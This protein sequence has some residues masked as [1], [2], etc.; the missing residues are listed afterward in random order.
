MLRLTLSANGVTITTTPMNLALTRAVCNENLQHVEQSA[1]ADVAYEPDLF[2]LLVLQDNITAS[3]T[4]NDTALFTGRLGSGINWE[5]RG[6]PFPADHIRVTITDNTYLLDRKTNAEI[7]LIDTTVAAAAQKICQDCGV[8]IAA[9]AALPQTALGVFVV[10]RDVSYLT[11]LD[12]L[13]FQYGYSFYFDAAGH[14]NLFHYADVPSVLPAA[15]ASL[16]LAGVSVSHRSKTHG[17][18]TVRYNPVVKKQNELVYF[19]GGGYNADGSPAPVV[20]QPGVYYPFDAAP[21]VETAEGRVYQDFTSGYAETVR[22]YNGEAEFRRSQKTTLLYTQNHSLVEDWETGIVVDRAEFESKRAS[23]RVRNTGAADANLYQLSIRADAWYRAADASVVSGAGSDEYTYAAEYI[24]TNAPA[25]QLSGVLYRYFSGKKYKITGKTETYL[26][27]GTFMRIDTGVSGFVAPALVLSTVFD[28]DKELFTTTWIT[29]GDAAVD[30]SRFKS[31]SYNFAAAAEYDAGRANSRLD[32]L[33]DGS[34]ADVGRPDAITGLKA[35]ARKDS[36]QVTWDPLGAGL[37]NSVKH[38]RVE[39]K[40]TAAGNWTVFETTG[41]DFVYA[42]DRALDGYPEKTAVPSSPQVQNLSLWRVRARAVNI[43]NEV[44]VEYAPDAGGAGIDTSEYG[45]WI[46]TVPNPLAVSAAGRTVS[47]AAPIQTWYGADGCEYQIK[48]PDAGAAWY[49]PAMADTE[50]VYEN[51]DSWRGALNGVYA[52]GIYF[53]QQLPLKNQETDAPEDTAYTYRVRAVTRAYDGAVLYRSAW[54]A[55][56]AAIAKGTGVR[57]VVE[58]AIGSAQI[59]QSAVQNVHIEN[60]TID[61]EKFNP[62]VKPPRK[63]TALPA[64]PYDGYVQGDMVILMSG[65]GEKDEKLYRLVDPAKTGTAGWSKAVDGADLVAK[66]VT[67][68]KIAANT[69]SAN[70]IAANSLT[71]AQLALGDFTNYA[72]VNENLPASQIPAGTATVGG[73]VHTGGYVTKENAGNTYLMWC[74]FTPETFA[75]EDEFYVEFYAKAAAAATG[76]ITLWGYKSITRDPAGKVTG[77]TNSGNNSAK[78]GPIALTTAEQKFVRTI[79]ITYADIVNSKWFLFG[80]HDTTASKGQ[81]YFRKI[82]VRK[83][84]AGEMIVDGAVKA[85]HIEAEAVIT[86]KIKAGAVTG[87]KIEAGTIHAENLNVTARNIVNPFTEGTAEGWQTNGTVVNVEGLG[88]VLKLSQA[89]GKDFLS[90]PFTVLPEDIYTFEFGLES[91]IEL[92]SIYLGL[93]IGL[94]VGQL[95]NIRIYNFNDKEWSGAT[96]TENAYFVYEFISQ[97]R[98]YFTTYILG[99]QVDIRD[100]P[101]PL[102]T[103]NAYG[104]VCIQLTGNDTTCRIRSGYNSGQPADA[105]WYLIR[106]QVYRIGASKVIAENILVRDLSAISG[107]FGKIKDDKIYA[108]TTATDNFWDMTGGEFR[109]GNNLAYEDPSH[110]GNDDPQAEYLHY[111][112]GQGFFQKIKNFIVSSVAS[113]LWGTF[114]VLRTGQDKG[115]KPTFRTNPGGSAGNEETDVRGALRVHKSTAADPG[116][117]QVIF[118]V[119]ND[120]KRGIVTV[121][122]KFHTGGFAK[123]FKPIDLSSYDQNTYY[124]VTAVITSRVGFFEVVVHVSLNSN[125]PSWSAHSAGFSCFQHILVLPNEWAVQDPLTICLGRSAKYTIDNSIPVGWSQMN[126]SSTAVLWLRGGGKY[127]VWDSADSDWTKHNTAYTI[128]EQTVAPSA[129]LVFDILCS[130][131][132][133]N[134][135]ATA[136]NVNGN[137][138]IAD[139]SLTKGAGNPTWNGNPV[140]VDGLPINN[141]ANQNNILQFLQT[142]EQTPGGDLPGADW[143]HVLKMNHGNGD[144]Y[145]NRALAFNFFSND[146]YTRKRNAG[147][148]SPWVKLLMDDGS[149]NAKIDNNLTVEGNLVLKKKL[150]FPIPTETGRLLM[151]IQNPGTGVPEDGTYPLFQGWYRLIVMSDQGTSNVLFF[152]ID[153]CQAYY[154]YGT[155]S[156][157]PVGSVDFN[158][159]RTNKYGLNILFSSGHDGSGSLQLWIL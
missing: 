11:V 132:Y 108:G 139:M 29:I 52:T 27:P 91:L 134:L 86:E 24:Y 131:I 21:A 135:N 8:T 70:E 12:A 142:S 156:A 149:G 116:A 41:N 30:G 40:K 146:I 121:P 152:V 74:N 102:Y 95:F 89:S 126:N 2:S 33:A 104:I 124:P 105:A 148:A 32:K 62:S 158:Y 71:A 93:Y 49:A 151:T 43:F 3:I 58:S 155:N 107:T 76:N 67:A 109:V 63:V 98:K 42:F 143:F 65:T 22:K 92:S 150:S 83:K 114:S 6:A 130:T 47:I 97:S 79:K 82:I 144:T 136:L 55:E 153:D 87:E 50:T 53:A 94:T 39:I 25:L 10:D 66:S 31:A 145:Y 117:D 118:E 140:A 46:P 59:Q 128:N 133:A 61:Y 28:A 16:L 57:D 159:F 115:A 99:S 56:A 64:Y 77:F 45:T 78:E 69:I 20:L 23:V 37:K 103:D 157:R 147:T 38:I 68:Q 34:S 154:R 101:A 110:N 80:F 129:T 88:Y 4:E 96:T 18:V 73:T 1:A 7:A 127:F 122:G 141:K 119:I 138:T 106:P 9:G 5:D 17:A 35:L 15:D 75:A 137:A 72:T 19:S 84:N 54:S 85:N 112:P 36:I 111:V 90:D 113:F 26:S 60:A 123:I 44:S 14:L 48:R 51:A 125:V 13:L 100:V 120:G 81:V